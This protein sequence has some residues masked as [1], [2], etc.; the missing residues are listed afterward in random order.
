MQLLKVRPKKFLGE[1]ATPPSKSQSMRALYFASLAKGVSQI[2]NLLPSPDVQKM[3]EACK[4]FG[5][6]IAGDLKCLKISG[7]SGT[8]SFHQSLVDCGNS[9]LVYRFIGALG[10]LSKEEIAFTGD[11]SIR[12]SRPILPLIEGL[13]QLGAEA[14]QK[15][16]PL[17]IRGPVHGEKVV[18]CGEDSQ[19]VSALLM[20]APLL[21]CGVDLIAE[22]LG[23]APYVEM[24][25]SWL[26]KL[27]IQ[28]LRIAENHFKVLGNQTYPSFDYKVPG[29]F[30]TAAFIASL[31]LGEGCRVS[32]Q[33]LDFSEEQGDKII[34]DH[35][36][37][38]GARIDKSGSA[39]TV[40]PGPFSSFHVDLQQCID[41]APLL[42]ALACRG[43][44]PSYLFNGA[45]AR[46]KES[47]RLLAIKIE[48]EKM[49]GRLELG[50]DHLTIYPAKLNGAKVSSHNDHRLAMALFIAAQ[51]AQ[52]ET[53][54]E[55]AQWIEKSFPN[56]E[57]QVASLCL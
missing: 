51:S 29:D 45:I 25:L 53:E 18:V 33:N 15:E 17:H 44:S 52:G 34:F 50:S 8:P 4:S 49:G 26:K 57:N 23:E 14:Y 19:P 38:F 22:P 43:T 47:D 7:V 21:P 31:G 5:A 20:L 3:I 13:R 11:A 39:I 41:Q 37:A 35:L 56:F 28:V 30:S 42:A 36:E 48:L 12:N 2:E 16:H 40:E 10:A 46:K 24:T 32:I 27:G 54:I 55:G 9:G 1:L 6:E